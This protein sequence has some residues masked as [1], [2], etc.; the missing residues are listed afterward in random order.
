[1]SKINLT[2]TTTVQKL[3]EDRQDSFWYNGDVAYINLLSGNKLYLEATGEI[4]LAFEVDGMFY[5]GIQAVEMARDK[6]LNDEGLN[7]LGIQDLFGNNN[8]FVVIKV[9]GNG[10]VISDDLT[11]VHSYDEGIK[12]LKQLAEEEHIKEYN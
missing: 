8:W 6:G 12:Q 5:K 9:N 11:V 3:S 4:R 10:D 7:E 1:M 2:V